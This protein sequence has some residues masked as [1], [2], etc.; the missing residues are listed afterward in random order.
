LWRRGVLTRTVSSPW[1]SESWAGLD[2][3]THGRHGFSFARGRS[4]YRQLSP[5]YGSR[6][7][8]DLVAIM[9]SNF[10][11]KPYTVCVWCGISVLVTAGVPIKKGGV[12]CC[13]SCAARVPQNNVLHFDEINE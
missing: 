10:A 12:M 5:R 7:C 13:I 11:P 6:R 2:K 8:Q 4:I 9:W 1:N 3:T